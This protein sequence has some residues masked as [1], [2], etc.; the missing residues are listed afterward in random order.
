M[1]T[2]SFLCGTL[3]LFTLAFANPKNTT[4][5]KKAK[6]GTCNV[7]FTS[8][9]VTMP[10][11]GYHIVLTG[12]GHRYTAGPGSTT[13]IVQGTYTVSI[14]PTGGAGSNHNYHVTSCSQNLNTSGTSGLFNNVDFNCASG[15]I[16]LN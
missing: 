9:P 1:K 8:I 2:L 11:A 14:I 6:P 16:S 12:A 13:P 5:I 10:P 3:M 4:H 7:T 15:S